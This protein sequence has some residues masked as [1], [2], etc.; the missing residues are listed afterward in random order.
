[1]ILEP[2]GLVLRC[3]SVPFSCVL[4]LSIMMGVS[5]PCAM[6]LLAL[7]VACFD[8][9]LG[10]IICLGMAVQLGLPQSPFLT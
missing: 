9:S 10:C 5:V 7:R 2:L 6:A 8:S 1:M 4:L 3:N